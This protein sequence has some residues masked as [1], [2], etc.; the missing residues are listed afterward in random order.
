MTPD[1][2]A[3]VYVGGLNESIKKEDLQ[4]QFE[5]FGKL[6]KVWV[7][8]NPP[9]FAFIEFFNMDEAEMACSNMNGTE[10]MGAKLRVEISR[11]RGRGGRGGFKGRGRGGFGSRGGYRGGGG[12][13]D[14]GGGN[15][16]SGRGG[17]NSGRYGQ[18]YGNRNSGYASRDTYSQ[19]G[20]GGDV[21]PDYYSG[22]DTSSSR[23]RSRSPAGR[24]SQRHLRECT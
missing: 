17:G 4:M 10:I 19:D 11:G 1:G 23:Y 12:G 9:G 16:Y 20:Y 22:K 6:N 2:Y 21:A 13:Y 18:S 24:G 15:Y 7:A 14:Q 5:K 8:F 3:R